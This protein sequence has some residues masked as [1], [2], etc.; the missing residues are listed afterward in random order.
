MKSMLFF[1]PHCN[2]LKNICIHYQKLQTYGK[3][4]LFT[5][6]RLPLFLTIS[7]KKIYKYDYKNVHSNNWYGNLKKKYFL[8]FYNYLIQLF[9]NLFPT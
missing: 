5:E 6:N 8:R 2:N 9:K 7:I 3:E 4:K 1:S